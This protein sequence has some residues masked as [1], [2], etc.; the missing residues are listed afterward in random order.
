MPVATASPERKNRGMYLAFILFVFL[1]QVRVVTETKTR[2]T[3]YQVPGM[4]THTHTSR[5]L[6]SGLI[7]LTGKRGRLYSVITPG[8]PSSYRRWTGGRTNRA[9]KG[10]ARVKS[11]DCLIV[12]TPSRHQG[13][14]LEGG[15][16]GRG[17]AL[18]EGV[19]AKSIKTT[20]MVCV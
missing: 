16:Q 1:S 19:P 10:G 2:T 11:D 3:S 20:K 8:M 6:E 5:A 14:L 17:E 15:R 12:F 18:R 13:D 7:T 9:G 4:N